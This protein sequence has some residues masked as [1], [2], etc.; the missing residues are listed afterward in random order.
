MNHKATVLSTDPAGKLSWRKKIPISWKSTCIHDSPLEYLVGSACRVSGCQNS[1]PSSGDWFIMAVYKKM[2]G[3]DEQFFFSSL[4]RFWIFSMTSCVHRDDVQWGQIVTEIFK[5]C[6][7]LDFLF[8]CVQFSHRIESKLFQ[9][10]VTVHLLESR[11]YTSLSFWERSTNFSKLVTM[12][13]KSVQYSVLILVIFYSFLI[14]DTRRKISRK[15][16]LFKLYWYWIRYQIS[17]WHFHKQFGPILV[18]GGWRW[19]SVE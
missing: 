9:F 17:I 8:H 5:R 1:L 19:S 10:Y 11:N 13:E 12:N 2:A 18:C 15:Y 6:Y 4:T 14:W 7:F 3:I 16:H